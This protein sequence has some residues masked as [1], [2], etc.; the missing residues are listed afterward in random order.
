M[1]PKDPNKNEIERCLYHELP[2]IDDELEGN[3]ITVFM[4]KYGLSRTKLL[5]IIRSVEGRPHGPLRR[6][7]N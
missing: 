1:D 5:K 3:H 6:D 2:Q 4:K 7:M